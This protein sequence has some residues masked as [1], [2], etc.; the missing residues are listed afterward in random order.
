MASRSVEECFPRLVLYAPIVLFS[1]YPLKEI[2]FLFALLS[3]YTVSEIANL[4]LG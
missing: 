2:F 4:N 3:G 1:F